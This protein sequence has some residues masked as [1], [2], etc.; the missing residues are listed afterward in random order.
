MARALVSQFEQAFLKAGTPTLQF[1]VVYAGV[2][3]T[4][5]FLKKSVEIDISGINTLADLSTTVAAA[6]RTQATVLGLTVPVNQV[7]LPTYS[8]G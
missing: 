3:V 8:L 1:G 7:L 4:N 5:G 2:D 6:V